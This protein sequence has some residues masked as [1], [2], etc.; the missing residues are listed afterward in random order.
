MNLFSAITAKAKVPGSIY[1]DLHRNGRLKA[2]L[3]YED[4]DVNYRWVAL[5]NWTYERTFQGLKIFQSD[6]NFSQTFFF[7]M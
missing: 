5:E 1:S 6:K 3:Y 7:L 2:D 4:N